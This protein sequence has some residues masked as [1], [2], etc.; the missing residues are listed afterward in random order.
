MW[1][2]SSHASALSTVFFPI[3]CQTAAAVQSCE[4]PLDDPS[5]GQRLEAFGTVGALDDL[6][7][8]A[9]EG[10]KGAAQLWPGI[11]AICERAVSGP[12]DGTSQRPRARHRGPE[13]RHYGP[14]RQSGWPAG[15]GDDVTLAAF[16][17]LACVEAGKGRAF[18][19]LHASHCRSLWPWAACSDPPPRYTEW[20]P[21]PRADHLF[22]IVP[23]GT[24]RVKAGKQQPILLPSNHLD[25]A[26]SSAYAA[27]E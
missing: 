26:Q 7:R 22:A 24:G 1:A 16:D 8:P 17:P 12:R 10:D 6:E 4:G 15:V 18:R 14:C 21:R 13:F 27:H 20:H 3:P 5:A 2:I 25:S 9:P 11:A 19:G 23:G